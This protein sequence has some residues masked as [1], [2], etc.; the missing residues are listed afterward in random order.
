MEARGIRFHPFTLLQAVERNWR[1]GG[2]EKGL[3]LP[4]K[5]IGERK[6]IEMMRR[7]TQ[8]FIFGLLV[9]IVVVYILL[10]LLQKAGF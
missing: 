6:V 9:G 8:G 4:K 2:E 3:L 7:Q 5:K 10:Y 1:E